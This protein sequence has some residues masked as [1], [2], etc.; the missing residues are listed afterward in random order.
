[1]SESH[2]LAMERVVDGDG[3]GATNLTLTD[4]IKSDTVK[5]YQNSIQFN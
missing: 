1:M 5:L 4:D 2:G 3:D